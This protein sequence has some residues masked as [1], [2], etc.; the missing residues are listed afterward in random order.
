[1][2]DPIQASIDRLLAEAPPF[3]PGQE[4]LL[5]RIF[6]GPEIPPDAPADLYEPII[7][8]DPP[9]SAPYSARCRATPGACERCGQIGKRL[10]D[11]CH[12]HGRVRGLLC[13]SCNNAR[14]LRLSI[15][16]MSRCNQCRASRSI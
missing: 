1:V 14:E 7:L 2:S 9:P 11:H 10:V 12:P 5:R 15:E 16:W 13:L 4:D 6:A 3:S 8:R